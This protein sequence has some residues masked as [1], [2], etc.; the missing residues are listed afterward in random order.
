MRAGAAFGYSCNL[1]GLG[2]GKAVARRCKTKNRGVYVHCLALWLV[3]GAQDAVRIEN[4]C[5]ERATVDEER[6]APHEALR[7]LEEVAGSTSKLLGKSDLRER[8][9]YA[10][11][12]RH[13]T[14]A[15][16]GDGPFETRLWCTSDNSTIRE[17]IREDIRESFANV[18]TKQRAYRLSVS[19]TSIGH[20]PVMDKSVDK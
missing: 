5:A 17:A 18:F 11:V 8:V 19:K 2:Q 13:G 15:V 14:E 16:K 1:G 6:V 12:L 20:S 4:P 9:C 3:I 10:R 7:V